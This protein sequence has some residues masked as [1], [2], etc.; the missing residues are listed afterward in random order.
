VTART[1]VAA[2][3]PWHT[4]ARRRCELSRSCALQCSSMPHAYAFT[5]MRLRLER[6][7][8]LAG[9]LCGLG[10]LVAAAGGCVGQ[11]VSAGSRDSGSTGSRSQADS[12]G[13]KADQCAI[14]LADNYDQSCSEGTDCIVAFEEFSCGGCAVGAI[15]ASAQPQYEADSKRLPDSCYDAIYPPP[16]VCCVAG[17]CQAGGV[18]FPDGSASGAACAAAGGKCQAGL[19]QCPAAPASAQDCFPGSGPSAVCCLPAT[20]GPSPPAGDGG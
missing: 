1:R 10:V 17:V 11:T 16:F 9:L 5:Q 19:P 3:R 2:I 13:A 7:A 15:N 4:P 14:V 20:Q 8:A 12:G 6:K 18:C